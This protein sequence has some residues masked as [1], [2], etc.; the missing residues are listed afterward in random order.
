MK[1]RTVEDLLND[2]LAACVAA[3]E[4]CLAQ[5]R[6]T[7]DDPHGHK[8]RNDV[9]YLAKLMKAFARLTEALAQLRGERHQTI[10]VKREH[11]GESRSAIKKGDKEGG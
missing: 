6:R 8:R 11:V 2:Q 3:T 7:E 5:S 9:A 1:P 4:D 10:H